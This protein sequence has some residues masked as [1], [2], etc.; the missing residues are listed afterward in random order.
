MK[1]IICHTLIK[2]KKKHWKFFL[3]EFYYY[4]FKCHFILALLPIW[5]IQHMIFIFVL[6]VVWSDVYIGFTWFHVVRRDVRHYRGHFNII[7]APLV[8]LRVKL[9]C[10]WFFCLN[11]TLCFLVYQLNRTLI[12]QSESKLG[13]ILHD[14]LL[15]NF[16]GKTWA[17]WETKCHIKLG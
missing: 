10:T 4:I 13:Y 9:L 7:P 1:G 3:I 8:A 12:N 14:L 15:D 16:S 5:M 11:H 6:A 17:Q 2:N